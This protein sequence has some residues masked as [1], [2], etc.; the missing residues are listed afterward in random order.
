MSEAISILYGMTRRGD[1][2]VPDYRARW[3]YIPMCDGW[4]RLP[5]GRMPAQDLLVFRVAPE[6]VADLTSEQ[7]AERMFI[8]TN[9]PAEV[10]RSEDDDLIDALVE[11]VAGM[12]GE[13]GYGA[14]FVPGAAGERSY[15]RS[16]SIGDTVTV[17]GRASVG[18]LAHGWVEIS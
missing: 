3:G 13:E 9:A 10:I 11:Q 16:L 12:G 5:D 14:R 15:M 18:C 17:E 2:R 8:A 4:K 7:V 6:L 1:E